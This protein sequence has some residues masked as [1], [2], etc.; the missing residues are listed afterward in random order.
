MHE[1]PIHALLVEDEEAHAEMVRGALEAHTREIRLTVVA[2]L[3]EART[4]LEKG[5]PD[6]VIADVVLPDGRGTELVEGGLEAR[7]YPV[8]VITAYGNEQMAVDT[9]KAGA[10]DYVAK[11]AEALADMP[12]TVER[13]L[14]QWSHIMERKRAEEALRESEELYRTLVETSPD[15]ITLTDLDAKILMCNQQTAAMHG[16]D[17][18]EE[19]AGKFGFE[20]IAPEDQQRAMDNAQK[21]LREGRVKDIEY[22]FVKKDGTRF[23]AELSAS[24]I[25]DAEGKPKAFMALTRDITERKRVEEML[26]DSLKETVHGRRLLMALSQAAQ[27]VQRAR[28]P[29]EIYQRVGEEVSRLS[30]NASVLTLAD[31]GAHLELSYLS[32]EPP[33]VRAAE[34][35]T[36][37]LA[38]GY[39]FPLVPDGLFSQI[40]AERKAVFC[41]REQNSRL[42]AEA[43]PE[44]VRPLAARVPLLLEARRAIHSPLTVD[45]E[46]FGLLTVAGT[47]LTEDD[48]AAVEALAAATATALEN[49]RLLEELRERQKHL[50]ELSTQ[51]IDAQEAERRR[52]S[53]ELHDEIG[54]A[55]TAI[56]VDLTAIEKALPSE[57]TATIEERLAEADSL[58][59]QTLQQVR[60]LSLRLRPAILDDL[61]LVPALRWHVDRFATRLGIE[62]QFAAHHLE[63]RLP[64]RVETVLYRVVQ[65]ALTNVAR[66]AQ[67][68]K[69]R[70]RLERRAST[71]T[72]SVQDDGRG[73]DVNQVMGRAGPGHGMGLWGMR[74]RVN[75]LR[76]R[77]S[78]E[79][80]PG[81]GTRVSV[82]VGLFP[83]EG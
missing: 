75:L 70:V 16:F 11:S 30:F 26:R 49:A 13:A 38:Q 67:A 39:R 54:Q 40:I 83:T 61:G 5:Q 77:L 43:L 22:T 6:L 53:R 47:R 20:L 27:A 19:I 29:R 21:T 37:L 45:G 15:A 1:R 78:V 71:V 12:R 34:K 10:L 46:L 64:S 69:V 23:P 73:F 52:I 66:H 76:G 41:D 65:E 25:R 56:R 63:E 80:A 55:L 36:G 79:S 82:E 50:R 31:D 62:V 59:A 24:L 68:H 51:I 72:A 48:V 2:S 33:L 8:V 4:F 35:L 58:V 74:E 3:Q 18:V 7:P 57:L 32:Y 9:L 17:S 60:E 28:T 81:Q 44:P 14:R 42:V